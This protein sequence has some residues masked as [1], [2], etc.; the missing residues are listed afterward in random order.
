M[1]S[2]LLKHARPATPPARRPSEP[3]LAPLAAEPAGA[4]VRV[5]C[6]TSEPP[7]ATHALPLRDLAS[8]AYSRQPALRVRFQ[9]GQLEEV[10]ARLQARGPARGP[11]APA[12]V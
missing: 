9:P 8:M 11:A 12:L 6:S 7:V 4:A 3:A 5:H 1:R 10:A 2:E